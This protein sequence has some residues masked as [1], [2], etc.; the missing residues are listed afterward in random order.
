MEIDYKAIALA[1]AVTLT[2]INHYFGAPVYD[3]QEVIDKCGGIITVPGIYAN[4]DSEVYHRKFDLFGGHPSLSSGHLRTIMSKSMLHFWD[5][6][7]GNPDCAPAE[8]KAAW[9][10]GRAVHLLFGGEDGF[11]EQFI[12]RPS[13]YT[14]EKTGEVKSWNG[15]S[16]VCKR[17]LGEAALSNKAVLTEADMEN[18]RGMANRLANNRAV[19]SGIMSGIIEHSIF[20]FRDYEVTKL[21]GTVETVRIWFKS[22][23]DALPLMNLINADYKTAAD[24]SG[25]ATRRA[26]GEHGYEQQ[27]ALGGDAIRAVTGREVE[28]YVLIFQE[29]VRPW[30]ENIK[31]LDSA[32]IAAGQM[33][34]ETAAQKFAQSWVNGDWPTYDDDMQPASIPDWKMSRLTYQSQNGLLAP[35]PKPVLP[36]ENPEVESF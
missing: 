5:N 19:Q 17:W 34:N 32:S 25:V 29:K 24:A 30:A 35:I 3:Y 27:L 15:N 8:E 31:P 2:P 20:F 1:A 21:D 28:E 7:F 23:P 6:Y 10:F 26:I 18:I 12:I 13:E 22:R 4:L 9:N 14:D 16:N 36:A 11:N 33:Q